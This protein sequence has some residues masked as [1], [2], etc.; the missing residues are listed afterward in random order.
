M[1]FMSRL[2]ISS[3]S[4]GPKRHLCLFSACY[5]GLGIESEEDIFL[6]IRGTYGGGNVKEEDSGAR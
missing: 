3:P 2:L 4:C 5:N 1:A 6:G